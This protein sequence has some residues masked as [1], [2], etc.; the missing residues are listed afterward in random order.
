MRVAFR[1]ECNPHVWVAT[2][3]RDTDPCADGTA[4]DGATP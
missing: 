4:A 3:R 2:R 1:Q